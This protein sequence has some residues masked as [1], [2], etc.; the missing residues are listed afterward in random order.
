MTFARPSETLPLVK[1]IPRRMWSGRLPEETHEQMTAL[2]EADKFRS[3]SDV[4]VAGVAAVAAGKVK[5]APKLDA[6]DDE[7]REKYL[8]TRREPVLRPNGKL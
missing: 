7:E 6:D 3:Q 8:S 2:V 4:I 1:K 5:V